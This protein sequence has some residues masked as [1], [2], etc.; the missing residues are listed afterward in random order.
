MNFQITQNQESSLARVGLDQTLQKLDAPIRCEGV[1]ADHDLQ[2]AS[3]RDRRDH[4]HSEAFGDQRHHPRVARREAAAVLAPGLDARLVSAVDRRLP[5]L[6]AP[7]DERAGL[8][9]PSLETAR[10]PLIGALGRTLRCKSPNGS[11]GHF[12]ARLI[13]NQFRNGLARPQGVRYL[14]LIRHPVHDQ[15]SNEEPPARA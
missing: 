5:S 3:V 13:G 10:A 12:D 2:R 11:H 4:V 9:Q 6:G 15:G 14:E 8:V 1:A 7:L